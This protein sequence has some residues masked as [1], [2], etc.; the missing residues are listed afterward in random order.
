MPRILHAIASTV[1]FVLKTTTLKLIKFSHL[2]ATEYL[3][4]LIGVGV[5][6]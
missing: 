5:I 2:R 4:H 6:L 1:S 3:H